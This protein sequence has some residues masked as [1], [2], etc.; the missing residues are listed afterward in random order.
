VTGILF[1]RVLLKGA[2]TLDVRDSNVE[3]PNTMLIILVFLYLNTH[4][5]VVVLKS[6]IFVSMEK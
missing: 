2:F 4:G 3:S 5:I 1:I 6:C